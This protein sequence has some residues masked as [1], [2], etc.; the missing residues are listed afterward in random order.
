[1]FQEE[2]WVVCRVFKKRIAPIRRVSDHD[3]PCSWYDDHQFSFIPELDSPKQAVAPPPPPPPEMASYHH[4]HHPQQ[5]HHQHPLF[6][7]KPEL[8]ELHY[9]LPHHDSSS[10]FLQLPQL[11][12]PKLPIYVSHGQPSIISQLDHQQDLIQSNKIISAYTNIGSSSNHAAEQVTDWR[13]FDKLVASQL[14]HDDFCKEPA[15]CSNSPSDNN[16]EHASASNS[17]SGQIELWK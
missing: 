10:S 2:G 12:S 16:G 5:Q 13:V 15:N 14:S 3:S 6:P 9:H 7:C 4:Y 8:L 11:E 1:M 17:S